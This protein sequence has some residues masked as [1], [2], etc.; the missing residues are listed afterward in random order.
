[1]NADDR[2]H[3]EYL[4][5]LREKR[6][7]GTPPASVP[8]SEDAAPTPAQVTPEDIEVIRSAAAKLRVMARVFM[9][10]NF[11]DRYGDGPSMMAHSERLESV[12]STL[13]GVRNA[14]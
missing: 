12:I 8:P 2:E 11:T 1:M 7:R 9:G 3:I 6:E 10:D 5:Y 14:E 13:T 4:D